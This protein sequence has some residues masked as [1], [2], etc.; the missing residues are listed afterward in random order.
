MRRVIQ[1]ALAA[2]SVVA[3]AGCVDGFRGSNVQIDLSPATPVQASQGATPG[4]GQL[5]ANSHLRL[6]GVQT[7][8]GV[9]RLFELQRFEIHKIV[10]LQSPCFIDVPPNVQFP[11]IHVSQFGAA[12]A[13]ATGITDITMPPPGATEQQQIDAA[14]AVKR[15]QNIAALGGDMAIKVVTSATETTYP[16]VDADCNGSGL[17]PPT[18]RD[19]ASNARRLAIC[20]QAWRDDPALFEGTD[21]VLT[22]PIAGTTFGFVDGVNPVSPTPIGGAQFFVDEAL[23]DVDEYA[24]FIQTDGSTE[25]ETL[26][27]SGT[28]TEPTRGVRHV[29]M[30]SPL[31]PG[32]VTA[33]LAVFPDLGEDDVHF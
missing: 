16:A 18:C 6:Y 11:G 13:E 29:H 2:G 17:P 22:A 23:A 3:T 26:L 4:A 15:M 28:A 5:P 20:Q 21:R 9:D 25:P 31:L 8:D 19:E 7:V 10:D 1:L 27:L 30:T 24:V 12:V 32:I 14:T 33:E